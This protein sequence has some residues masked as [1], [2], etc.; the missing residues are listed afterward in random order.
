MSKK[1]LFTGGGTAGHVTVNL[2]L[3]PKFQQEGWE[4]YYIGSEKGIERELVQDL[5]NVTYHA[6]STGKL[7]R[8]LS[9]E[10]IKDPFKVLK[11]IWQACRFIRKQ[12]PQVIFSKG[13]F[14]S[15]PVVIG[16]WLN[17]VPVLIHESDLTP[18]LA[19]RL[20]M[21]FATKVFT[22]FP[23]TTKYIKGNKGHYLG[24]IVREELKQGDAER[25][26]E[27]CSF[28]SNKPVMLVMGGSLG[29]QKLNQVIRDHLPKL[30]AD[31]QVI[32][33]CG[34]N[35]VDES[36]QE[37]GYCQFE[38]IDKELPDLI[39]LADIV[40]SRA[41]SNAIFEFLSLRKPMLLIP[42]SRAASRGDQILNARSFEKQGFAEVLEEEELTDETFFA[43]IAEVMVK[44][45]EAIA[46]M[47]QI[48]TD[49]ALDEVFREIKEKA[50]F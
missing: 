28:D 21:P 38:Y 34:K 37:P 23:E 24:A 12:K 10:N 45:E 40:V 4:T 43:K 14:V 2:A 25:G 42:L 22:T 18:G 7:R 17:R 47:E 6:V 32:H 9:W 29:S 15:V 1:V 30:L 41:G 26:R 36:I 46:K 3:I 35:N 20:A 19:N 5:P 50:K 49:Q 39:Q 33:L 44:R 16:G 48:K 8:Y 27:F 13:G 31:Y 11:G